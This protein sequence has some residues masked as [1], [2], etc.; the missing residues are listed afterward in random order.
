MGDTVVLQVRTHECSEGQL[1][2]ESAQHV[3]VYSQVEIQRDHYINVRM[4]IVSQ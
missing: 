4:F 3:Y 1:R 2:A